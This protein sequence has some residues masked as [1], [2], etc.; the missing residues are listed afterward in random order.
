M[1]DVLQD[2]IVNIK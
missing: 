2:S 1:C